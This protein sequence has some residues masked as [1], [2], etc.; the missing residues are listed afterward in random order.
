MSV[1]CL[2]EHDGTEPIDASFRA[3]SLARNLAESSGEAL[4]A[5][6][7]GAAP[8][9][10][11]GTLAGFGVSLVHSVE[12]EMLDA[13]APVAWARA[14]LELAAS[15][16]ATAIVAAGTERGNEVMAHAGALSGQAMVANCLT[17]RREEQRNDGGLEPTT[18]GRE[19]H[20]RCSP[21]WIAGT[22]HCR[23][24]RRGSCAS[25]RGCLTHCRG[26]PTGARNRRPSRE[27][28]GM[29]AT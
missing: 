25:H 5:A 10:A 13:Y 8:A 22:S 17:A 12:S 16:A 28:R 15:L 6:L 24:R 7:I 2:V 3:L 11:V 29:G 14:L 18:L 26:L 4:E 1:L 23:L 9:S 20:R 27:G 19:P 21:H